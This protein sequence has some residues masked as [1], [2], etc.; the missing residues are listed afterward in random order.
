[1][2]KI[3]LEQWSKC[4]VI[5]DAK[6]VKRYCKQ[7]DITEENLS[8]CSQLQLAL[9]DW[10]SHLGVFTD[11]VILELI[12]T[13]RPCIESLS[14]DLSEENE[15]PVFTLGICDSRWISCS[16]RE[17]FFDA[18]NF[19]DVEELPDYGVTHIMCDVTQLYSR[20]HR[21]LAKIQKTHSTE[22]EHV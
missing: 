12:R 13:F 11:A 22:A 7:L 17:N 18:E 15:I 8:T 5:L 19:E 10:F 1:M 14:E 6:E 4:L 2:Q 3:S 21:R 20:M 9:V 16:N